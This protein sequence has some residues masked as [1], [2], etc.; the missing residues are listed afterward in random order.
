MARS[1]SPDDNKRKFT[2][3]HKNNQV[4]DLGGK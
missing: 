4:T 1:I 3:M 2:A